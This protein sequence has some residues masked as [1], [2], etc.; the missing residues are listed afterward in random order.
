MF[1]SVQLLF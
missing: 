1:E